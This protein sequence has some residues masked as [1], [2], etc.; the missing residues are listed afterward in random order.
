M[1]EGT[2][3]GAELNANV[4]KIVL[5]APDEQSDAMVYD[6]VIKKGSKL[7]IIVR[8]EIEIN[9]GPRIESFKINNDSA[10]YTQT[11]KTNYKVTKDVDVAGTLTGNGFDD[12]T[13]YRLNVEYGK[14]VYDEGLGYSDYIE[15]EDLKQ[16]LSLTGAELNSG[17]T[18]TVYYDERFAEEGVDSV[19]VYYYFPDHEYEYMGH[20]IHLKYVESEEVQNTEEGFHVDENGEVQNDEH[21]DTPE[22]VTVDIRT[23][24]DVN[25]IREDGIITVVSE[26]PV[27]VVGFRDGEW[28]KLYEWDVIQN[29][30]ERTNHYSI[31]DC[32]EVKVVLKGDGNMDGRISI[33]DSNMINKSKVSPTLD[34]VY[35]PLSDIE[36]IVLDLNNNGSVTI[37]DSTIINKSLVSESLTNIYQPIAWD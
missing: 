25:V 34:R 35:R 29:G 21:G 36:K 1:A 31:G 10:E 19:E 12:N 9:D 33:T 26:K 18:H 6:L 23:P 8:D 14:F 32:D 2:I 5:Q 3:T 27:T 4:L 11:S 15:F 28:V 16:E 7:V 17:Y 30:E 22:E 20:A 24:N 37:A 13:T